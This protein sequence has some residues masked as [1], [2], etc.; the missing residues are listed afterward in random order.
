MSHTLSLRLWPW[1]RNLKRNISVK[2][3]CCTNQPHR[4]RQPHSGRGRTWQHS[5]LLYRQS[6]RVPSP[7]HITH[8][9]QLLVPP[10]A[11]EPQYPGKQKGY[12]ILMSSDACCLEQG[13][14]A[15]SHPGP[16]AHAVG[17][18]CSKQV[19]SIAAPIHN[20]A[21]TRP[22][23]SCCSVEATAEGWWAAL[24]SPMAAN[25]PGVPL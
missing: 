20:R 19:I 16:F 3:V 21:P 8:S 24:C 5:S 9:L 18:D 22:S 6:L 13:S 12:S 10:W 23:G 2:S 11:P 25:L 17:G 14:S 4:G 15:T 1:R 7:T